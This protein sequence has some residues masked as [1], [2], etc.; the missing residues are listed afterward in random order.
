MRKPVKRGVGGTRA[1][2]VIAIVFALNVIADLLFSGAATGRSLLLDC[3]R[4]AVIALPVLWIDSR[5]KLRD[6]PK[7]KS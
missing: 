1:L 4:T 3:A 7:H 5:L 2:G 6:A